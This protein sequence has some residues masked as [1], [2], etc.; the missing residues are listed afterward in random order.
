MKKHKLHLNRLFCCNHTK[1]CC[2]VNM[3]SVTSA[4][5][6]ITSASYYHPRYQSRS[7]PWSDTTEFR[8]IGRGSSD[9]HLLCIWYRQMALSVLFENQ[10]FKLLSKVSA[11]HTI[12]YKIHR[13]ICIHQNVNNCPQGVLQLNSSWHFSW[14]PIGFAY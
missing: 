9:C 2:C 12:E 4:S 14:N 13:I 8:G 1:S 5:R 11:T 10:S 3:V 7:Y 6:Y